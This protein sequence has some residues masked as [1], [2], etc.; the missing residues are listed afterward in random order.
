MVVKMERKLD[1][2]NAIIAKLDRRVLAVA[3]EGAGPDWAAYIGAVEGM[4][5]ELEWEKV[6]KEG[7]KLSKQ[8]AD[9]IF[10]EL[11]KRLYRD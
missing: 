5:H 3:V 8:I 1:G 6:A 9:A 2:V 10:P 11:S 4:N 7:N